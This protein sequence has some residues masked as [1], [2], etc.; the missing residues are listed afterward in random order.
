MYAYIRGNYIEIEK[1]RVVL[2][3]AGIGYAIT[4]PNSVLSRLP[5]QGTALKL[6]THLHV[7]EDGHELYGFLD[8]QDKFFFEKLL[9]VSGIGPKGAVAML[10]VL[11]AQ[12]LAVAIVT[13]D[14][15]TLSSAPGIGK[16]TA[17]RLILELKERIDTESVLPAGVP[18]FAFAAGP[19]AEAAEA[20]MAL[21]YASADAEQALGAVGDGEQEVSRLVTLALKNLDARRR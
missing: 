5:A 20:L 21:G 17:Q 1:G 18:S 19:R 8:K 16:K 15:K 10:S 9:S 2:D 6:F 4:V 7:K 3:A 14:V 12:Q 13:G 11:S